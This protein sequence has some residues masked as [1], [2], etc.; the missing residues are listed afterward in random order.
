[1]PHEI[2]ILSVFCP[3]VA[4]L[5]GLPDIYADNFT[6]YWLLFISLVFYVGTTI[7]AVTVARRLEFY[8]YELKTAYNV[9]SVL[10]GCIFFWIIC[11]P[12]FHRNR[13]LVSAGKA[14]FR[15]GNSTAR[16]VVYLE[17]AVWTA[18]CYVWLAIVLP[19]FLQ[20]PR[21][22]NEARAVSCVRSYGTAQDS[23]RNLKPGVVPDGTGDETRYF[24]NFRNLH[25]YRNEK[26][27]RLALVSQAMADAFAGP[28]GGAPT[29]EDATSVS[30]AYEGFVFL[31]D[32]YVANNHLWESEYA[33]VA[34]PARP[35]RTGDNLF[36][37]CSDGEVLKRKCEDKNFRL[38]TEQESPLH[39][40]GR[41]LWESL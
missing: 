30:K 17:M 34:Y 36:W 33:L 9:P 2:N 25:Y 8:K 23:L 37:M 20:S 1:M 21:R 39:P 16:R 13:E 15:S 5:F 18:V 3:Y 38:L 11:L 28:T 41:K 19:S 24:D 32:P 14:P 10:L 31:E 7:H 22:A 6:E 12:C 26:G 29:P 35:R 27:N 4:L 40:D